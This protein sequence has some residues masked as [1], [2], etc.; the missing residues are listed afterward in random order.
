MVRQGGAN[1][2]AEAQIYSL[3]PTPNGERRECKKVLKKFSVKPKSVVKPR[4][5]V[6][7]KE[8]AATGTV[9]RIWSW[10]YSEFKSKSF[11]VA[12]LEKDSSSVH[13]NNFQ[14]VT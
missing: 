8:G 7:G 1:N 5:Y 13:L 3:L 6:L 4:Q 14:Q 12:N 2:S 9:K 10:N 11:E